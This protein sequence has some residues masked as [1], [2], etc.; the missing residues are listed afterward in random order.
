MEIPCVEHTVVQ[1]EEK[2][3]THVM[4]GETSESHFVYASDRL[5]EVGLTETGEWCYR[6]AGSRHKHKG[7]NQLRDRFISPVAQLL[8]GKPVCNTCDPRELTSLEKRYA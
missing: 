5:V 8:Q 2:C 7:A 4:I 1:I 3:H 6:L